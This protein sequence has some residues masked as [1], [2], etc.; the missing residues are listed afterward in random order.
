MILDAFTTARLSAERLM[1]AHRDEIHRMHQDP[2]AMAMLGGVRDEVKTQ[3]YL[4]RNLAHWDEFGFGLWIVR[5]RAS[6]EMIGRGLLRHLDVEGQ[7]DIETGYA[8]YPAWW[9]KG[10]ATEIARKCV[11]LGFG[12]L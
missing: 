9:G 6:G 8:F 2:R 3:E 11:E 4:D 10:L 1:P 12:S 7:D 5:D